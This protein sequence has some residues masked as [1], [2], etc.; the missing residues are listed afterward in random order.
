MNIFRVDN[1]PI[2]S[3]QMLC[4]KHIVKMP[5]ETAQMLCSVFHRYDFGHLV[6]Y[7]EAYKNHPCT[8]WAGDSRK[9]YRWLVSHGVE[10]CRE[11]TR[12]YGKTHK[13]QEVIKWVSATPLF[14]LDDD[15][16]PQPQCMPDEYKV[17]DNVVQAYKNYY[18]GAKSKIAQWNKSRS[19][20]AWYTLMLD[21]QLIGVKENDA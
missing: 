4:D 8:R 20:P 21:N 14:I 1:D 13:C 15:E 2:L 11:Y 10:L 7:K 18:I 5:L 12:R 19:V 17:L 6:K 3:A 9:N 16:T